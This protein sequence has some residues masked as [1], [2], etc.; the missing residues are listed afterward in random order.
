M[1]PW[2]GLITHRR[3]NLVIGHSSQNYSKRV[4]HKWSQTKKTFQIIANA[5]K[6]AAVMFHGPA[7]QEARLII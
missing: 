3:V 1:T 6:D 7:I 5:S 2:C 4:L